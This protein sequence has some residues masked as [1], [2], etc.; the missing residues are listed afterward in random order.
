GQAAVAAFGVPGP[1]PGRPG[2][3]G[4][5]SP[6]SPANPADTPGGAKAGAEPTYAG[7]IEALLAKDC[8]RCHLGPFRKM[9]T[10]GEVKMYVDNGLLK[11]LVE[12]GGQ[13]H[14]FAGPDTRVFLQWIDAGAPR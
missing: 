1:P 9:T 10:Y 7:T 4:P 6:A 13:M 8:M 11:T 12:P 14:R 2:P 3:N 5:A